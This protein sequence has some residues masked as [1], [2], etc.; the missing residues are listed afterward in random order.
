VIDYA[1][2]LAAIA[3]FVLVRTRDALVV[4]ASFVGALSAFELFERGYFD[5]DLAGVHCFALMS[6]IWLAGAVYSRDGRLS[7]ALVSIALFVSA[8]GVLDAFMPLNSYSTAMLFSLYPYAM[9][10]GQLIVLV[11]VGQ[12]GSDPLHINSC[13]LYKS[14]GDSSI[15][16]EA[17]GCK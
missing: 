14:S 12:N 7:L 10:A 3:L 5:Y 13:S 4:A 2:A 6:S 15:S 9:I 17:F 11:M 8:C 1:L 16:S